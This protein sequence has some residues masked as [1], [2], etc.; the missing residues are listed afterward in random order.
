MNSEL[1]SLAISSVV[2]GI[3]ATIVMDIWALLLQ[4]VFTVKPLN[5]GL[6]GRWL[7]YILKGSFRHENIGAVKPVKT[8]LIVGWTAHY[9]IG[10]VFATAMIIS[11]GSGWLIEPSII[12]AISF[13][14]LTVVFPF[15]IMQPGM[16]LG[17]AASK[18]PQPNLA[19]FRSLLTHF[20]FGFGLYFS[21]KLMSLFLTHYT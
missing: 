8:E 7:I 9:L 17:I 3:G 20:I 2:I 6:V 13:G 15:F 21:A 18:T 11:S 12:P 14:L 19:R 16:G 10:V 4:R 1:S 5:Y